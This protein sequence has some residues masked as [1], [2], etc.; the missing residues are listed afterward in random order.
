MFY[1]YNYFRQYNNNNEIENHKEFYKKFSNEREFGCGSEKGGYNHYD[2]LVASRFEETFG[3]ITNITL[4]KLP[5]KILDIGCGAGVNLPLSRLFPDI[6]YTG[7]D[8]AEK[9]IAYAQSEYPNIEFHVADAF[10]LN[11]KNKFDMII[12]S[13]VLILYKSEKDRVSLLQSAKQSLNDDGIIVAVIWN[14]SFLTKYSIRLSRI[15]GKI[16]GK[17]LP[18]DYMGIHLTEGEA[19]KMFKKA[20]LQV[21]ERFHV[22]VLEGVVESIKYLNLSKYNRVFGSSEKNTHYEKPQNILKDIKD[23]TGSNFLS[24]LFLKVSHYFPNAFS[25]RSIYVL[26]K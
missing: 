26:K 16:L 6:H 20:G 7:V 19:K 14:D 23:D 24:W 22:G 5:K 25:M 21:L 3:H 10:N 9:T 18:M 11:L 8:Y 2:H 1:T 17:K 4:R 12:I 15:I 13:S